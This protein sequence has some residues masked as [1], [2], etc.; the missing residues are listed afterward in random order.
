MDYS[1]LS[2]KVTRSSTLEVKKVL[3]TVPSRM[4]GE[5]VRVP[6]YHDRL[7]FYRE[8]AL[9]ATL[10]RVYLKAAQ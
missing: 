3:Y 2:L 1:E 5:T 10:P 8:Q 4:I 6:V 7:A 9:T